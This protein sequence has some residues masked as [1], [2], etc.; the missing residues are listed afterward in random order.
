MW[1]VCVFVC[2]CV[3]VEQHSDENAVKI[4][5]TDNKKKEEFILFNDKT[6]LL[7]NTWPQLF[8]WTEYPKQFNDHG[9]V[10]FDTELHGI[11]ELHKLHITG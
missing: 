10:H 2:M 3:Y 1:R 9:Q 8:G 4:Y 5:I 11:S 6:T 7:L